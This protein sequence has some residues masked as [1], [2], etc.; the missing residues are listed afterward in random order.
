[1]CRPSPALPSRD[2]PRPDRS[3]RARL[4]RQRAAVSAIFFVHG[5]VFASWAARVPA[6]QSGLHLSA[7]VLG[8]VLAGPGLGALAGSRAGGLLVRRLGS[9]AVSAAAPVVLS[10]PLCLVPG[11]RSAASLTGLLVLLGA[12]DGCTSV[13]MNA[14]AV[15]V[16]RGYRR[17]VV[18]S[19]HAVRSVGA[20]AG[21]LAAA[22]TASSTLTTQFVV[23]AVVLA[24]VSA[25]AACGLGPPGDADAVTGPV[26]RGAAAGSASRPPPAVALLAL[27]AFLAALVEDAPASWSGVYLRHEG[28]GPALAAAGYA[29]FCAGE[30]VTRVGNDRLVDRLGWVRLIRYGTACCA[31]ALAGA[32]LLG[33]P[34]AMLAALVAAGAGVSAV[35]PGAFT[36]A[37]ELDEP[38]VAIGHVGFAGNLGWLAV[39][40]AVGGL[41]TVVGLPTALGLLVA[42]ATAIAALAPATRPAGPAAAADPAGPADPADPPDDPAGVRVR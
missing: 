30:V 18:N 32:L 25:A 21:G 35:F 41:A 11:A 22:A 36:A 23:T 4:R 9:R 42:C 7:G 38:A 34:W 10:V 29:A 31:A 27:M 19:L 40:P 20:V 26:R 1:M 33:G 39:S 24:A 37:G 8:L 15:V 12:A 28:A 3:V 14:Q 16:Q 2:G 13:A 17:A 5:A 6:V